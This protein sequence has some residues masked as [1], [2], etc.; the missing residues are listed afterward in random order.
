M[1]DKNN[2]NRAIN[3]AGV[4]EATRLKINEFLKGMSDADIKKINDV[5]SD[6]NAAKQ[7]LN[8]PQAKE[9]MKKFGNN[10]K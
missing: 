1:T 7:L 5:L 8:S 9:I 6:K 3:D 2:I 4:D 10:K